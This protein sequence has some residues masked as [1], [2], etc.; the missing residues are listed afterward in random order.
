MASLDLAF[1]R[2]NVVVFGINSKLF[3]SRAVQSR[4]KVFSRLPERIE[5]Y[6]FESARQCGES[7]EKI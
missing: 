5:R 2:Q 3:A 6:T 1:T 4:E 7:V